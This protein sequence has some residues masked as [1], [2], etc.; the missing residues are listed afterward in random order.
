[1]DVVRPASELDVF[2]DG[3]PAESVRLGIRIA[4]GA[5]QQSVV[6]MMVRETLLLV[7]IGAALGTVAS[8]AANRYIA[9]QLFGVTGTSDARLAIIARARSVG[10]GQDRHDGGWLPARAPGEPHRSGQGAPAE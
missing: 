5:S 2:D 6:W 7:T 9:G 4:V 3:W 8:L 1:M 10:A